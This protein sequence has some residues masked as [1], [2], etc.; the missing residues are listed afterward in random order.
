MNNPN[1]TNTLFLFPHTELI[2]SVDI[3]QPLSVTHTNTHTVFHSVPTHTSTPSCTSL[4]LKVYQ[5]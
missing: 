1:R 5:H 4:Y 3:I 2:Y